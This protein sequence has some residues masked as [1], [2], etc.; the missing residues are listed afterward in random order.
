MF[1][2]SWMS[3]SLFTN[4]RSFFV[5]SIIREGCSLYRIRNWEFSILSGGYS[6]VAVGFSRF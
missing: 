3:R 2:V 5:S 1:F 4:F 6:W